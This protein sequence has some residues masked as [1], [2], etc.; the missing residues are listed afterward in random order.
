VDKGRIIGTQIIR[1]QGA[2]ITVQAFQR[3]I[4]T[5]DPANP[6]GYLTERANTGTDF[7][8]IFPNRVPQ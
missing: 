8:T 5:Y 4:L 7:A 6:E 2:P 3:T 1:V